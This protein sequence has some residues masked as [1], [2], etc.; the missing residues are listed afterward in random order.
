MTNKFRKFTLYSHEICRVSSKGSKLLCF[1]F[2][3][4]NQL[5]KITLGKAVPYQTDPFHVHSFSYFTVDEQSLQQ[6]WSE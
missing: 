3:I 6:A 1:Y 5:M 4:K 2:L